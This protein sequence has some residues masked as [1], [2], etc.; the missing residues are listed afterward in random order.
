MFAPRLR[1]ALL[2]CAV[3]LAAACDKAPVGP[4]VGPNTDLTC[5]SGKIATAP[6]VGTVI[7][8]AAGPQ[9]CVGGGA[10]GAQYA[11]VAFYGNPDSSQI[12]T[13][14]VTAQGAAGLST[15]NMAPAATPAT[16]SSALFKQNGSGFREQFDL[17]L[18]ML[19]RTALT[20]RMAAARASLNRVHRASFDVIPQTVTDGQILTLNANANDPCDNPIDIGARVVTQTAGTII[21]ADTNN[22]AGGFT[23]ADYQSFATLFD[24]LISPVDVQNFGQPT[25]IDHNGKILILFTQEVNKLTPRGSLGVVGGFTF[26]RDLFPVNDDPTLGL[27]GCAGSNF[28]EMFYVMVPDPNAVVSDARS[29]S[30][31][32]NL[33]PATLAHE[34][35]HLIN[36]GRRLYVNNANSFEDVWLNEGLSHI[37]EELFYYRQSGLGPRQ[38][39]SINTITATP[40]SV[41]I[42][43]HDQSDNIARYGVF[44]SK[45]SQT[46]VY[47]GNDSLETRGATW[48]LLRYLADRHNTGTSD[49]S[50]WQALVNTTFTGQGNIA[51]VFG[52]DYMTQIRD[53]ATSVFSDDLPGV[54]KTYQEPSWNMRGI[55]PQLCA[56]SDCTQR[57]GKFP[58]T[59]VPLGDGTP[60]ALSIDAGG[61]AY[62]RFSVPANTQATINWSGTGGATVAPGMQ[63]TVVRSQ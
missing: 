14:N 25:D 56:N 46:S 54:A 30:D 37:A 45:P 26:E 24:T 5:Q 2:L 48:N 47:A 63:F 53:W 33:T 40:T 3:S 8:N 38:N 31:V 4:G 17:H 32:L 44:M 62:L 57:I 11:L 42:F 13:V 29:K 41:A 39:L 58:L 21:A 19:A 61:V 34:Y 10:T 16:V 43:N 27:Q 50:T 49:A 15:A 51:H 22:P 1:G 23:D 36:A 12:A 55:F 9:I 6:G 18:R 60:A 20:R 35:Q 52:S 7:P 28:G 59:V